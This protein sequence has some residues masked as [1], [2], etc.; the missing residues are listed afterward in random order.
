M[1][2]NLPLFFSHSFVLSDL[3]LSFIFMQV[4]QLH[5]HAL[6]ISF[7][8]KLNVYSLLYISLD[9]IIIFSGLYVKSLA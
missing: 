1:S 9:L 3:L 2:L 8:D 5:T 6:L 4:V 7:V